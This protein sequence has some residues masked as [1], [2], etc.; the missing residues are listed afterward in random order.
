MKCTFS[1]PEDEICSR[2]TA[3]GYECVFP[4]RKPRAPGCV[5]SVLRVLLLFPDA[6]RSHPSARTFLFCPCFA[7]GM[8]ALPFCC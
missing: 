5:H 4:G 7:G 6:R 1:Q 8:H 3:G 2:C